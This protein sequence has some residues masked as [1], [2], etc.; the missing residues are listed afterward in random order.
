MGPNAD[1]D[2]GMRR[3]PQQMLWRRPRGIATFS[4]GGRARRDSSVTSDARHLSVAAGGELIR[5]GLHS[6]HRVQP[7]IR[8][9]LGTGVRFADEK[10]VGFRRQI[11]R[12]AFGGQAD[13]KTEK[14]IVMKWDATA[15]RQA[16]DTV[17]FP[18]G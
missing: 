4:P 8:R 12:P 13:V 14:G 9:R 6:P 18:A 1:M 7:E 15:A 5:D 17:A 3:G 11:R 2:S 16:R 10:K